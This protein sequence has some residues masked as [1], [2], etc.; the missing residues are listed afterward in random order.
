MKTCVLCVL[1]AGTVTRHWREHQKGRE[2]ST[3]PVASIFAWTRG[4]AFRAKLDGVR[5]TH[6]TW[7]SL[8]GHRRHASAATGAVEC[9]PL[10]QHKTVVLLSGQAP[11]RPAAG[12]ELLGK[13]CSDLEK[14]IVESIEAGFYT[15]VRTTA[16]AVQACAVEHSASLAQWSIGNIICGATATSAAQASTL[17]DRDLC[18]LQDLAICVH[19]TTKVTPDQY[20]YT[21]AFMDKISG[22]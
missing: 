9:R 17:C 12:N 7:C 1:R 13:F 10:W 4:L 11:C 16:F 6:W 8:C 2:T 5:L 21:N 18:M 20:L 19:G 15:K 14:S 3:N 22:E